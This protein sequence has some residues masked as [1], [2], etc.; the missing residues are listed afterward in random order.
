MIHNA[1]PKAPLMCTHI[2]EGHSRPVLS[3]CA[4]DDM[5]FT[6]SKDRT[7]KVWDLSRGQEIESLSGHHNNVVVVRYNESSRL[8]FSVSSAYVKVWDLRLN[9]QSRC[10]KTLLSSGIGQNGPITPNTPSRTHI[11]PAGEVQLNDVALNPN[12]T[13]LYTAGGDKVFEVNNRGN[14]NNFNPKVN[15][16]PPHYDG[17]QALA[18]HGD[19]LFSGSRDMAIKKWDLTKEELVQVI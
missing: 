9:S 3:V 19:M 14:V 11:L 5:L 10:I 15:L 17:I 16:E 13:T 12:G 7:V 18:L 6:G 4:T 2:A 8:V 1:A